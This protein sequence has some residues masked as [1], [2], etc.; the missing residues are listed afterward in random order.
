MYFHIKSLQ[1]RLKERLMPKS[2]S[3]PKKLYKMQW[4]K[5]NTQTVSKIPHCTLLDIFTNITKKILQ[6]NL[7][8]LT[9]LFP[10]QGFCRYDLL[11]YMT[12]NSKGSVSEVENLSCMPDSSDVHLFFQFLCFCAFTVPC[13][14]WY[15]CSDEVQS[16]KNSLFFWLS[17]IPMLFLCLTSCQPWSKIERCRFSEEQS[18]KRVVKPTVVHICWNHK[19]KRSTSALTACLQ[20]GCI[21]SAACETTSQWILYFNSKQAHTFR[22]SPKFCPF[23]W[24][25]SK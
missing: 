10:V 8:A 14:V 13:L 22:S 1:T 18:R 25:V 2:N 23:R 17:M 15:Q 16:V 9:R 3:L 21:R 4:K 11:F 6:A 7:W 20:P 24:A 5:G 12:S 19:Q